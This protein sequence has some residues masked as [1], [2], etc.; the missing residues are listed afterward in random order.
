[1][2]CVHVTI[3]CMNQH[4]ITFATAHQ[5]NVRDLAEVVLACVSRGAEANHLTDP[6]DPMHE[7]FKRMV[8]A[9]MRDA[10]INADALIAAMRDYRAVGVAL[11]A[12]PQ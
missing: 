10:G 6:E 9:Y 11:A 3:R 7:T 1:M 2:L 12:M 4:L 5:S 8:A